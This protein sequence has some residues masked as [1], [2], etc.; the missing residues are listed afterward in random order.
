MTVPE[1]RTSPGATGAETPPSAGAGLI[2]WDVAERVAAKVAKRTPP[3][4]DFEFAALASDFEE[5][6][7]EAETLVTAE[8]GLQSQA[9]PAR[10]RVV[11]RPAWVHA[12]VA[13]FQRLLRPVTDKLAASMASRRGPG[14]PG[15]VS[16]SVSGAQV[17]LLLGWMSTRVLGQYDQL[18][19]EEEHPEDQ[20]IVYY[21]GP[22]VLSLEKKFGFPPREF[23]LWL[24]LHEVTHRAQFT[25][26]PWMRDHFLSLVSHTLEGLDPDPKRLL[27]A[28]R[29]SADG[30]RSGRNPLDDG[31][32]VTLL[33]TPEQFEAIQEIGGLMSLLEGHGDITMD[34]AGADR[35]P[36]A[37][38]FA[39]VL[40]ERRRQ[41]GMAKVVSVLIG[42]DAKLR[43][44]E[45]GERF[46]EAVEDAGGPEML[47]RVW[48]APRW[49]PTW[50]EIRQPDRWIA[51]AVAPA[52]VAQA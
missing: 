16:R 7:A 47:A 25:G 15:S 42:L 31:G 26:V 52:G 46:I 14:L 18:L 19:I 4:A 40:R 12:N 38:R 29:R 51:R 34:R 6:T 11:D 23:R 28:L 44:Y 50:P 13:S 8:T 22:N 49:L 48:T 20:D 36:N 10:A 39:K 30:I 45:Q 1:T 17:G 24:A 35:I 27:D 9:G 41:G 21:V 5:L 3:V 2:G 43:Q 32:L 37:P 33:A